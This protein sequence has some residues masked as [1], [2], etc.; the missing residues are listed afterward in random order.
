MTDDVEIWIYGSRAR[1]DADE[2]SDTDVL[3]VA[4]P[5]TEVDS[6][7]ADLDYPHITVSRY[8]WSE[9]E[10]MQAYG[11]L[12][13]HHLRLEGLRV[14]P[15]PRDPERLATLIA[16]VPPFGRARVDLEGFRQAVKEATCSLASGGWPDLECEVVATV[17]RH[18]AI[19]GA[20]CAGQPVFGRE[21]PFDVAC[22]ALGYGADAIE[23][24]VTPATAWRKHLRSREVDSD[25][26]VAWIA[27]VKAFL[28][29]LEPL[30][31]G[32][33]ALLP[34]AA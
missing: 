23:R 19:L 4:E 14:R 12:Y 1:G 34:L 26:I 11:S 25:A 30:I 18:A 21:L 15:A 22:T 28:E 17:A 20:Y 27:R 16:S 2:L 24:L 8:S 33:R 31:D 29:D 9:M 5:T 13:I 32:Y 7:V 10:A 3:V 6:L